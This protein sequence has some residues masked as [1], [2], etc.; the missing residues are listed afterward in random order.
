MHHGNLD[1]I[2]LDTPIGLMIGSADTVGLCS[3]EFADTLKQADSL[4]DIGFDE[5]NNV[6]LSELKLQLASYF[7]GH[8]KEFTI[9]LALSG[10]DFQ[11]EVWQM[12]I[13]T[14]F[15]TRKTYKQQAEELHQSK[16]I[17]AVA[18]ANGL[19][20]ILILVPCHR[21]LGSNGKLTG[22]SGGVWR[23]KWLLEHERNHSPILGTLF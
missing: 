3:L 10:T 8:L 9:S 13:K 16:A 18:N 19:N 23:K 6:H 20:K 14:P 11:K 7:S 5:T 4:S 15:G 22:Y 17:R 12:L 2:K 1:W 21:I